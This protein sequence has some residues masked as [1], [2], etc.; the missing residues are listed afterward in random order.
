MIKRGGQRQKAL[1]PCTA[2]GFTRKG[3]G[4]GR[5]MNPSKTM[6]ETKSKAKAE[7]NS[8]TSKHMENHNDIIQWALI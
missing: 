7:A 3:F 5:E 8:K 1:C 6:A 2:N 4:E